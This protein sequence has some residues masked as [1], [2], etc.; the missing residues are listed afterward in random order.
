MVEMNITRFFGNRKVTRGKMCIVSDDKSFRCLTL[1]A[2]EPSVSKTKDKSLL[3]LPVGVYHAKVVFCGLKYMVFFRL[4]GLYR[5]SALT[6][7]KRMEDVDA[8][9][10]I[11][12]STFEGLDCIGGSVEVATAL[13]DFL[14]LCMADGNLSM[15]PLMKE[16]VVRIN[17]ADDFTFDNSMEESAPTVKNVNWDFIN[18]NLEDESHENEEK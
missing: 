6:E 14:E 7:G 8:G 12:G 9:C 16:V 2:R 18:D 10:I 5:K 1:E 15:K 13:S 11:V 4:R 3:A 17:L